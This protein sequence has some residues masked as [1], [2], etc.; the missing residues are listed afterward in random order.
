M[1]KVTS[2]I[3]V[4]SA[5]LLIFVTL[6]GCP[7]LLNKPPTISIED[8]TINEGETLNI[9]LDDCSSDE[10][11]DKLSYTKISGVGSINDNIYTYTPG[12]DES[13]THNVVIKAEDGKGGEVQDSFAI[14]VINVNATPTLNIPDQQINE[15]ETLTLD[16]HDY[17]TDPDAT[18]TFTYTLI[19]GVGSI[20]DN[21]YT[22]TA[23]YTDE[24]TK[25]VT[26]KVEDN[27]GAFSEDTFL[28]TT[29]N[30]NLS[31]TAKV[32][33]TPINPEEG[34][35]VYFNASNSTDEKDNPETL[36]TR[37]DF[38]GDGDWEIGYD[39]EV[40]ANEEV[41]YIYTSVGTYSVILEIKDSDGATDLA[42]KTLDVELAQP[43]SPYISNL[44]GNN[45]TINWTDNSNSEDGYRI[46][47]DD[48]LELNL[49][50]NSQEATLDIDTSATRTI[51]I[52]CYKNLLKSLPVE[53]ELGKQKETTSRYK[54]VSITIP[55]SHFGKKVTLETVENP[56]DLPE[57]SDSISE[58][59][60]IMVE[61]IPDDATST[62]IGISFES[63]FEKTDNSRIP[64]I[65]HYEEDSEKWIPLYTVV[66]QNGNYTTYTN[67]FSTF[68]LALVDPHSPIFS[69]TIENYSVEKYGLKFYNFGKKWPI[70]DAGDN[71]YGEDNNNEGHCYGMTVTSLGA[72][73]EQLGY[74]DPYFN[75]DDVENNPK[76]ILNNY[77]DYLVSC[78]PIIEFVGYEQQKQILPQL[79]NIP[80]EFESNINNA[81]HVYK[82]MLEENTPVVL[83][84][85]KYVKDVDDEDHDGNT[86]ETIT[87]KHAVLAYGIKIE[88]SEPSY[89]GCF[90]DIYD[91]N[92]PDQYRQIR[93]MNGYFIDDYKDWQILECDEFSTKNRPIKQDTLEDTLDESY[94]PWLKDIYYY[95]NDNVCKIFWWNFCR[96]D[97]KEPS[98]QY[99][100]RKN[101]SEFEIIEQIND[102]SV[103]Y[104]ED[105]NVE[106]DTEYEYIVT[107]SDGK[108]SP[109]MTV[110]TDY[111]ETLPASGSTVNKEGFKVELPQFE[112]ERIFFASFYFDNGQW[113]FLKYNWDFE[114]IIE[115]N[116]NDCEKLFS[117]TDKVLIRF[118]KRNSN[119][120]YSVRDVVYYGIDNS[121]PEITKVDG[122]SGTI[123]ESSYTFTW[124]GEDSDGE[125]NHYEYRK[126]GSSW[127][128]YGTS[129]SYTWSGYSEG[130]HT[131]EVRAQDNDGAY[132]NT[133]SW[134]FSYEENIL[135]EEDFE[136]GDFSK[137][138]W[139]LGGTE[140][141]IIQSD[142][143][144]EGNYAVQLIGGV[145]EYDQWCRLEIE[146]NLPKDSVITFY[147]KLM[148]DI[149]IYN[150]EHYLWF[151]I[152]GNLA[153]LW[154]GGTEWGQVT[155]EIPAGTHTLSWNFASLSSSDA[156]AFI[157][158]IK[159]VDGISLGEVV[160]IP[161][162]TLKTYIL[163]FL[164]K[165][166]ITFP[167]YSPSL[168]GNFEQE[169]KNKG[170]A[171][172][173][174][175]DFK[176]IGKNQNI[177]TLEYSDQIV[178][179]KELED[180]TI[181]GPIVYTD[182][183]I[184]NIAGIEY[185]TN[186]RYLMLYYNQITD[187]TPLQN[188]TNL[189]YLDLESNQITDIMPLQNLT[190]LSQLILNNNQIT[191]I[192]PLQNL[193]NLYALDF[194][195]NQ[196][197]DL[198]PLHGLTNIERLYIGYNPIP[199]TEIE[200]L[201]NWDWLTELGLEGLN[202]TS[203]D[204]SF[205]QNL[206][207]IYFLDL[208]HNNIEDIQPL[209][210]NAGIGNYD[211]VYIRY[212]YLDITEGSEDMEDINA[213]KDRGVNVYYDPQNSLPQPPEKPS[214]PNPANNA[215]GVWTETILSWDCFDPN[216][217][218]TLTYDVYFGT[219]SSPTCV[220]TGQTAKT[221]DPGTLATGTTYYWRVD[222][223]DGTHEVEGDVWSFTTT[224]IVGNILFEEDFETGDFS[225]YNWVLGGDA[226]P[227][228]QEDEVSQ[229][230][231]AVQFGNIG[232]NQSSY[233]E[234]EVILAHDAVISFYRK[235]SSQ[236]YDYLQFYIDD[237]FAG[238][239]L[240]D[241]DWHQ[242]IR[243]IP[244]GTH[245]LKWI[246][247]KN[248]WDSSY[249]DT[250]ARIDDIK[251][252]DDMDLG[253]EVNF[254]DSN[255]KSIILS[256]LGK[257]PG[258][259]A[260]VMKKVMEE[261]D[262]QKPL[263]NGMEYHDSMIISAEEK[264]I[265]A[266]EFLNYDTGK[267]Y[268]KELLDFVEFRASRSGISDIT[269]LEYMKNLKY[270][271]LY[272]NQIADITPL[273]N[274][275]NLSE[276]YLWNN[277][278]TDIMPLQ[279]LTNLS[280]LEL[281]GNQIADIAPLQNLTNLS[282]LG[283]GWNQITDITPLKN[284][285]NL[286][287]LYLHGNQIT[288][289]TPLQNLTNLY[290]L[291][292]D[293]NQITELNPLHNLTN[294]RE[295]YLRYNPIPKT[296]I[297]FLHNWDWLINLGL[298]GLN[299][300][301]SD[302][303][304]LQ[305]LTNIYFLDLDHNNIE[306]IQPLVDNAGIGNYDS[307]Y[308]RYNYL[309]ITEGSEDMEDIN[310]LK[311]RGVN[312]YYDPQNSLPQPPEKPSN[313]NPSNGAQGIGINPTLS[314]ECS[315]P[316]GDDLTYDI[317]FGTSSN[318]P[319]KKT[320]HTSKSYNPGTLS[321]NT[322]YYWKIVAK[323]G[324]DGETE[325]PVW[326]FTTTNLLESGDIIVATGGSEG[327][328]I[329]DVSDPSNPIQVGHLDADGYAVGV[330]V[331]GNYAYVADRKNGLVI[332]D[333][334]AP[335]NPVQVGHLDTLYA[336]GVYI[337]G[338]YAYVADGGN[339]LVIVDIT[340]PTKPVQI[341]HLDTNYA[342]GVHVSGNYAYVADHSNGLVIA[343]V[344][345]PTNPVQ[346][347]HLDK[348]E[349]WGV[350]VS[351]NYAY[352]ADR[353]NGLV[354]A[355]ITDPT[356]PVQV[357]HLDTDGYAEGVHVS[358]N[359][360][361]VAD[362]FNGLVIVDI[363]DPTNPVQVGHLDTNWTAGVHVSGNYAYVAD[364]GNGLVIV[365]ITD[366][367]NPIQVGHLDT[368]D[369]ARGV[370]IS[371]NY[372]YVA[373]CE[374]GLVIVDITDPT[375]PMQIGHL[376]TAG[377]AYGVYISGNYAYVADS[378]GIDL[379]IVDITEPTNPMQVGYLDTDGNA[380]GVHVSGNYAY[381]ADRMN[382]LV[383]VDITD[384][385]NPMQVGHLDT[386]GYAE[387]VHVS[388]NYAYVADCGNGL[389]IVDITD[390]TNPVQVG[391]L[392]T[393]YALGVHVSG[394]YAYVADRMN[395][396]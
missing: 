89:N 246:Y 262:K 202:L 144:Y 175:E 65:L 123:N 78:T 363:T 394:N 257:N 178:Y 291:S 143:V 220:S 267:I 351:G 260:P 180:F 396:L 14:E 88:K 236:S 383:I 316:D 230:S 116:R 185:M 186:L 283:L 252:L 209:V 387:G 82:L 163:A 215:T 245:T 294:I 341:G 133:I 382:G 253:E 93:L 231:Y 36:L 64:V 298:E 125:I 281:G 168:S 229:G 39:E 204:I 377:Y 28:I 100:E 239:W 331:S 313:P 92:F 120:A 174:F 289:I 335:T 122:P 40:Y 135:F 264:S 261:R 81:N 375:N 203:S 188:L 284:L 199:K 62:P 131:F 219:D 119:N 390:P 241:I 237:V 200:F 15:G 207:N 338:N 355:D 310:A 24:G 330:H 321:Y 242:V 337:S 270:L 269:G 156:K 31:P 86:T 37:W 197:T 274:L 376:D 364:G 282:G 51:K 74:S 301:S 77:R 256:Y 42:Q 152:D 50:A 361:Y 243:E 392:D 4:T 275:T 151:E 370:Y 53:I 164:G 192:T 1:K 218:D 238:E 224:S 393:D 211:S 136:T 99:I 346:V 160:S 118:A 158:D 30:I 83:H 385:T 161:D 70:Y 167:I 49:E 29:E 223:S 187:I 295:L 308:I 184:S 107:R 47:V 102:M 323:D 353:I 22:Y 247:T 273:Q 68:E 268:A 372:A 299:L 19:T 69:H 325:G 56:P 327:I 217:E 344:T 6:T 205:L 150:D 55:A 171:N 288:D 225:K 292:L 365:D 41:S 201:H 181:F 115:F 104:F 251:I 195:S 304:F 263:E 276:L 360:A 329:F 340:D 18:D 302:I 381:V 266:P 271:Y 12:Y 384:P 214:N 208:D 369:S 5:I 23:T 255:L 80:D 356:K 63:G 134:S 129:E 109:S 249:E 240:G 306:D 166:P 26:I 149:N 314:W 111:F 58:A 33:F 154:V 75:M 94:A 320:G 232:D 343:D 9:N 117:D 138:E 386:D 349:A 130:D 141:P 378:G 169:T 177:E 157:D 165:Y 339:G 137:H 297:E 317:Y 10:D 309:D 379:V 13:G 147:R 8:Q 21:I 146:V 106:I 60:N 307:V 193:T 286:S 222:V 366:P 380:Y 132:S 72:Y 293:N 277:Q 196:I 32:N 67:D 105:N 48:D 35:K 285:T 336:E 84:L 16:L 228:I 354:I 258:V 312:V 25:T 212:N 290:I 287:W 98:T 96:P 244:A 373:D 110:Y 170:I 142:E 103:N 357:G 179:E 121:P 17:T 303:S 61:D 259:T 7:S 359:Y 124:S 66:D 368:D 127:V 20:T 38:D 155:R 52:I 395:G 113:K 112:G 278:I 333:I 148:G 79:L 210:D 347:G 216:V 226:Q 319:L 265:V 389:V 95:I 350:H 159:I 234:V 145:T 90:I 191:D 91:P 371:G 194:A 45:V 85:I 71:F 391:H 342:L 213:L 374:N 296:E 348:A 280:R 254:P 318:P 248:S 11:G 172:S 76:F 279:N 227:F 108:V 46:Y 362:G 322:T 324:K 140:T 34:E 305:N 153:G 250:T 114:N 315:D 57:E 233:L 97:K 54:E 126:D 101:D 367:T 352:V 334:T 2:F 3:I 128:N 206:T 358:G 43:S 388:G 189:I 345:D 173:I 190:N 198:D 44:D 332:V 235:V 27:K 59:Y 300:T 328:F 311:D 326:S 139:I 272:N 182:E 162:A 221:Y 176:E 73:K 87:K 183:R